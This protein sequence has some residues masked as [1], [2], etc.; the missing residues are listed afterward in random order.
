[1]DFWESYSTV[2]WWIMYSTGFMIWRYQAWSQKWETLILANNFLGQGINS[3]LLRSCQYSTFIGQKNKYQ[4]RTRSKSCR[5]LVGLASYMRMPVVTQ[6]KNPHTSVLHAICQQFK[7]VLNI[8][9]E[10]QGRLGRMANGQAVVRSAVY[11]T[12]FNSYWFFRPFR[13]EVWE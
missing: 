4:F 11:I 3:Y 12:I 8:I 6:K 13:I 10:W 2:G 1:M 9:F 5:S 7:T